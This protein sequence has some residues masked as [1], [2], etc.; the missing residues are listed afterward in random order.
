MDLTEK[1]INQEYK[2]QGKIVNLR[3]DDAL[4]PNGSTAKREIVEHNGGVCVAP[5]DSDYNL[6]F[7]KQF[8]YPYMEI[9]T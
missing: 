7:V 3:V 4:L 5:L 1:P 2:F 6:Y 9:V 8:R